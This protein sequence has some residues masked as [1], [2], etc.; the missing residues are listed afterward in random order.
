MINFDIQTKFS[1][2]LQATTF[3]ATSQSK[4]S[5]LPKRLSG[6]MSLTPFLPSELFWLDFAKKAY[7]YDISLK[8]NLFFSRTNS[9]IFSYIISVDVSVLEN[10]A[11][12]SNRAFGSWNQI[13][14]HGFCQ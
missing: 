9:Y 3:L 4:A 6:T 1:P 2:R 13:L 5:N 8:L 14:I 12:L 10:A 11:R 7:S